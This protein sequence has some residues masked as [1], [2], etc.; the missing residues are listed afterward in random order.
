MPNVLIIEDDLVTAQ[1]IATELRCHGHD[2]YWASDG[3]SGLE[4]ASSGLYDV[5]T[6]DRMLPGMDGLTL[7]A[8]LRER[9]VCTPILM[10]SALSDIDERVRGLRAGG[11]DYLTKPFASD[12]M[13]ARVEALARRQQ[14]FIHP[15]RTI[16]LGDLELDLLSRTARRGSHELKLL[17]TE[18]KLLKFMMKNSGQTMT[19]MMIFEGVWGYH[20]DPGTNLIDVHIAR[21]RRK[22]DIPGKPPLIHTMRGTGY[23]LTE[24]H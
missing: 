18:F 21:L 7:A 24:S 11:D 12:E 16:R 23:V 5:I 3:L 9:G 8:A 6:L 1:E 17:P 14:S 10:I 20:F 15:G 22:L 4:H 13:V 2:T 19:R